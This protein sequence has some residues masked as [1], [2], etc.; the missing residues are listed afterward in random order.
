MATTE[1]PLYPE[2][3]PE[4]AA[5]LASPRKLLVGGRQE[6]AADGS[7]FDSIDPA[8]GQVVATV[9]EGKAED[10]DR[11]VVAA[12]AALA[13]AWGSISPADRER[14]LHRFA[15]LVE[16]HTAELAQLDSLDSGKPFRQ[17][18]VV[19]IPLA[20]GQLRYFA[21]W[22]TKLEGA[23]IPAPLPGA[24]V[25]TRREPLGVV[26]AI[27][28]WNFPVCQACFKLAPA[29]AAGCTVVLK[30]A[31][32]TPTSALR[33]GELA[34]EAGI[35]EGV[36]NV[37]PGYGETAGRALVQHPGVAKI[38]FTGSDVVGKEIAALAAPTLK[39]VSLELG[40]KNPNIIFADADLET[41][42]ATAAAAI[43]FYTGQVCSAGS[44]L[45]VERSAY[46]DVV[47]TVVDEA[48]KLQLGPGIRDD[49]TLGPLVSDEQ[50]ARVTGYL[51]K[52]VTAGASVA[53]GGGVPGGSLA[54][55]FFHEPTVLVDVDDSQVVVRD[56][57]FGPVLVAQPFESV[58]E[59]A[60]RAN[61]TRM[62][63]AAGVWTR[64]LGKAHAL[65]G[66]LQAGTVWINS[67]NLF[68]AAAPW[69]GYKQSGY[70]RDG[71]RE[72]IEKYLQTKTVWTKYV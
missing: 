45:M 35:P 25:Y 7:T 54:A 53:C 1:T 50:R 44:R 63:L 5:F 10:V 16:Q 57:I 52:A 8:T 68:D 14:L 46:D 51:E 13:G 20:V 66:L 64:D 3:L 47:Q 41:A 56:E 72:G 33:L 70:G 34:L 6:D 58:E 71:G 29:L 40:G 2:V 43:F 21:G 4:V 49:T 23:T 59:V 65:A 27:V 36:L 39:H 30:P 38:A 60:T 37:V 69:G 17:I 22:V 42:A 26:G 48:G 9:A 19:D 11:A 12:R 32:Q 15:D 24:H 62:G 31:E 55:G 18:E 61:S 28:P 67:Y